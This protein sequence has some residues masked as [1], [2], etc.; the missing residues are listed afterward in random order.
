MLTDM[1]NIYHT[2]VLAQQLFTKVHLLGQHMV[3]FDLN[4]PLVSIYL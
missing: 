4:K 3:I 2:S 1:L